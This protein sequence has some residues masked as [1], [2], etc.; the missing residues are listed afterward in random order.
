MD[1]ESKEIVNHLICFLF[2]IFLKVMV[3]LVWFMI[4]PWVGHYVWPFSECQLVSK[5]IMLASDLFHVFLYCFWAM[6]T[7]VQFLI[8][9]WARHYV[10]PFSKCQS[11]SKKVVLA[12]DWS[13]PCFRLFLRQLLRWYY[14]WFSFGP[15]IMSGL[16]QNINQLVRKSCWHLICFLFQIVLEAMLPLL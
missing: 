4:F 6:V 15:G 12:S 8:F 11:V 5:E 1:L 2:Q 14:S 13:V 16:S 10:W 3:T 7:L 9:P